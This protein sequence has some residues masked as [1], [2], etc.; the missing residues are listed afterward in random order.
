MDK[1]GIPSNAEEAQSMIEVQI[2][3]QI[4]KLTTSEPIKSRTNFPNSRVN[5]AKILIKIWSGIWIFLNNGITNWRINPGYVTLR[6]MTAQQLNIMWLQPTFRAPILP[7]YSLVRIWKI[8]HHYNPSGYTPR[9]GVNTTVEKIK[10][11]WS[12][13][14]L[15]K[16]LDRTKYTQES[17]RRWLVSFRHPWCHLP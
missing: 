15:I 9:S 5:C 13:L 11:S 12:S 3:Q 14:T 6:L 1:P 2:N 7:V 10:K 4:A 8:C 17:W 16:R